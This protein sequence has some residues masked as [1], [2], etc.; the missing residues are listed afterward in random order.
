MKTGNIWK[1]RGNYKI[2][3]DRWRNYLGSAQF[4][5]ILIMFIIQTKMSLWWIV[6]GFLLSVVW[7]WVDVRYILSAE[8]E[9]QQRKNWEL[10]SRMKKIDHIETMLEKLTGEKNA[11]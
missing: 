8:Y 7:M 4:L 2:Y 6:G 5:L 9:S 3:F 1:D 11:G 10:T